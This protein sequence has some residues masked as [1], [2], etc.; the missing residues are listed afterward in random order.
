MVPC[1]YAVVPLCKVP[2]Q[3]CIF[4]IEVPLNQREIAVPLQ[5]RRSRPITTRS[6]SSP[7]SHLKQNQFTKTPYTKSRNDAVPAWYGAAPILC[8]PS[9]NEF[10]ARGT[11]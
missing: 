10:G 2:M 9:L 7:K 1:A 4:L 11:D 8:R 3:T 6:F 5:E